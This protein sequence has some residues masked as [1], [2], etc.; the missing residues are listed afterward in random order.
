MHHV[1]R[2]L[3]HQ[4]HDLLR[5]YRSD[6]TAIFKHME[7]L[8]SEFHT[9]N[10]VLFY[11]SQSDVSDSLKRIARLRGKP[12]YGT[13]ESIA[14]WQ[15]RKQIEYQLMSKLKLRSYVLDNTDCNWDK[16]FNAIT[17]ILDV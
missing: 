7:F 6:N 12:K 2:I 13:N 17:N 16:I 9:F 5:N 11:I 8:L 1:Q 14:F 10:P 3:Q 15:N 4:I